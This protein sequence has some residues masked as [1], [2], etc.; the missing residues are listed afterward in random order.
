MYIEK[1]TRQIGRKHRVKVATSDNLEQIIILG[2][3]AVRMPAS[4]LWE[5]I[6]KTDEAI[7]EFLSGQ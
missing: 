7:R 3:G 6:Q 2:S 5:E 4:E 1:V